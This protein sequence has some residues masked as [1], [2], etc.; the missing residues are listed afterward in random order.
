MAK[1]AD[2]RKDRKDNNKPQQEN[3][4]NDQAQQNCATKDKNDKNE[5]ARPQ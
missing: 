3:R 4:R 2:M 5:R 1:D